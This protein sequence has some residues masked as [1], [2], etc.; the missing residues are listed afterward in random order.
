MAPINPSLPHYQSGT[1]QGSPKGIMMPLI[2]KPSSSSHLL[3]FFP[4][5]HLTP[6]TAIHLQMWNPLKSPSNVTC[7]FCVFRTPHV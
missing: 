4:S 7:L 3:P 2:N 6:T 5:T 1:S